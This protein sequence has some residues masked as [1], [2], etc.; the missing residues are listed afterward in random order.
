[1][2][3]GDLIKL[4]VNQSLQ[5]SPVQNVLYYVVVT[6]PPSSDVLIDLNQQ[7]VGQIISSKWQTIVSNELT[8]DCNTLQ[9]V[10]PAPEEAV[11][12]FVT[13][14]VGDK[15]LE[16]LPAMDSVLLQKVNTATAGV[17]KKGRMYVAGLPE[18]DTLK[19]RLSTA[20][21]LEWNE[22]ATLIG[23]ELSAPGQGVYKPAWA[24]RNPASPFEI[25]DF[26]EIDKVTVLPRIAT[27]RR[28]RT[29]IVSFSAP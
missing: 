9:K 2:A 3:A 17:G 18:A 4:V 12:D 21:L 29:P 20:V 25:T 22:F 28:R 24:V 14:F 11:E 15:I 19:G 7:F 13:T 6:D 1:M 10:F 8:F 27:Q 5:Q 23:D 26:I 16:S